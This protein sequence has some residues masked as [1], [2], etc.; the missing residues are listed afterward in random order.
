MYRKILRDNFVL[1]VFLKNPEIDR[2][3][4][5]DEKEYFSCLKI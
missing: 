2:I 4:T 3:Y 5:N 1:N